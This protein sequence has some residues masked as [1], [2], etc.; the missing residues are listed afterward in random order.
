MIV[1]LQY[2]KANNQSPWMLTNC[3]MCQASATPPEQVQEAKGSQAFRADS[4]FIIGAYT[5]LIRPT[6]QAY[7]FLDLNQ[8]RKTRGGGRPY[9]RHLLLQRQTT[10]PA[11]LLLKF[12][13]EAGRYRQIL[14]SIEEEEKRTR[15]LVDV[16]YLPVYIPPVKFV[17]KGIQWLTRGMGRELYRLDDEFSHAT[18]TTAVVMEQ[19]A[20]HIEK[21]PNFYNKLIDKNRYADLLGGTDKY[22]VRLGRF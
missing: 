1:Q 22:P 7:L 4:D 10:L 17:E 13:T 8:P 9:H 18:S 19:R 5:D 11:E 6:E 2:I 20:W 15:H 16:V 21:P 3:D 14:D 12:E